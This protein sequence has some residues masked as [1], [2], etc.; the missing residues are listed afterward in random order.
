[1]SR[2]IAPPSVES[3]HGSVRV[4]V[5]DM[6]GPDGAGTRVRLTWPD[7]RTRSFLCL[8]PAAHPQRTRILDLSVRTL[9]EKVRLGTVG[10]M[11]DT[12]EKKAA[13]PRK[14]KTP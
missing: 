2:I 12:P 3:P 14:A 13:K 8:V 9:L 4:A 11:G 7:G 6:T 5:E 10:A 1:M